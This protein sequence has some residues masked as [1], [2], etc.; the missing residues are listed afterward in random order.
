[1]A[2]LIPRGRQILGLIFLLHTFHKVN[3]ECEDVYVT[4]RRFFS[5]HRNSG[6]NLFA[7]AEQGGG[8]KEKFVMLHSVRFVR[9]IMNIG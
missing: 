6:M 3:K 2:T 1:M 4:Q 5:A 8:T 7:V 9:Y